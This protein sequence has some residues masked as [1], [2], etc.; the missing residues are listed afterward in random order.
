MSKK[1]S[2]GNLSFIRKDALTI[3]LYPHANCMIPQVTLVTVHIPT[4]K[5]LRNKSNYLELPYGLYSSIQL[6]SENISEDKISK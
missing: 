5:I 1:N 6:I 4:K 2:L 3:L